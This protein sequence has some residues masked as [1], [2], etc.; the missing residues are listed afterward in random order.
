M[1]KFAT[2]PIYNVPL[3]P[4]FT[5]EGDVT[6]AGRLFSPILFLDLIGGAIPRSRIIGAM[7][8]ASDRAA[9]AKEM[10][11]GF[12]AV[13]VVD[14]KSGAAAIEMRKLESAP[15]PATPEQLE[16]RAA[17]D[18]A[19]DAFCALRGALIRQAIALKQIRLIAPKTAAK[20]GKK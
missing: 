19:H 17:C 9:I 10:D 12:N 3:P 18:G 4:Y 5:G 2:D 11:R 1:R 14:L 16:V 7:A 20:K 6:T 13:L 8:D 15:P